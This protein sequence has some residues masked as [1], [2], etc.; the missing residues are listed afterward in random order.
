MSHQ[1][2]SSSSR[3][4][5]SASGSRSNPK[6]RR[7]E[8]RDL[9]EVLYLTYPPAAP[10][11]VPPYP[12]PAPETQENE[13]RVFR[14]KDSLTPSHPDLKLKVQEYNCRDSTMKNYPMCRACLD[15]E[16]AKQ[17]GHQSSPDL[18]CFWKGVR[19]VT[20]KRDSAG[21]FKLPDEKGTKYFADDLHLP[22]SA[23]HALRARLSPAGEGPAPTPLQQML[24]RDSLE[25]E[26]MVA[27][28]GRDMLPVLCRELDHAMEKQAFGR[29]GDVDD[30]GIAR[31]D[32]WLQEAALKR[33]STESGFTWGESNMYRN[34]FGVG[35]RT[36]MLSPM[37]TPAAQEQLVARALLQTDGPSVLRLEQALGLSDEQLRRVMKADTIL[38]AKFDT[39]KGATKMG[40][41]KW[42]EV[43]DILL[44]DPKKRSFLD[45]RDFPKDGELA[46]YAAGL[47]QAF[48]ALSLFPHMP[49]SNEDTRMTTLDRH[50]DLLQWVEYNP[51][52]DAQSKI[53]AATE[54]ERGNRANTALHVDEA[55]AINTCVWTYEDKPQVKHIGETENFHDPGRRHPLFSPVFPE[56]GRPDLPGEP[57]LP[58]EEAT[59]GAAFRENIQKVFL[60]GEDRG[61]VAA[62]WTVFPKCARPFMQVAADRLAAEGRTDEN[63]SGTV[64]FNHQFDASKAFVEFLIEE[65]GKECAPFV[66]F[67]RVGETVVIPPGF[68]HQV[69]NIQPSLKVA[70]D[71]IPF[72]SIPEL[73][74]VQKE[75]AQAAKSGATNGQ[76]ACMLLPTLYNAWRAGSAFQ[77]ESLARSD[78]QPVIEGQ[79]MEMISRARAQEGRVAQIEADAQR[80][81]AARGAAEQTSREVQT[82]REALLEFGQDI[83]RGFKR[84]ADTLDTQ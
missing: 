29:A 5:P 34:F 3:S 37:L 68:P 2:Y 33:W 50:P 49:K 11:G 20:G 42:S 77:F 36:V 46:D 53:Y 73:L 32:S 60:K 70:K 78:V 18:V 74:L 59:V 7:Y 23:S 82:V 16:Q 63:A 64:L 25:A 22:K 71:L 41:L 54:L 44:A 9:D 66:I 40:K 14:S 72:N 84:L 80:G 83:S 56:G 15:T 67:Q 75:R 28:L 27:V 6:Y 4:H 48:Y 65:G 43:C 21:K 24:D 58:G 45:V 31:A 26:A 10:D 19:G 81:G 52:R 35:V 79:N 30:F 55:G 8:L 17:E 1:G 62:I 39:P 69:A 51:C 76:D 12:Q 47:T 13:R 61:S 57:I 38:P